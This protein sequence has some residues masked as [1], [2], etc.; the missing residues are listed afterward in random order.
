MPCRCIRHSS[1]AIARRRSEAP[2]VRSKFLPA[3]FAAVAALLSASAWCA[4]SSTYRELTRDQQH[5]LDELEQ[6]TFDYFIAS[7]NAENGLVADHW[8]QRPNSDYFASIAA[9]GFG[10]TGYGIGAERGWITRAEAAKRTLTTLRF[11]HD[12]TQGDAPDAS[13]NH[14]FFY[15]FLDMN[16]GQRY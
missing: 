12:A 14:G 4:S 13:G 8:P 9:V 5:M 7:T 10:L 11:F 6:R 16:T 15:H 2:M 3:L 1:I